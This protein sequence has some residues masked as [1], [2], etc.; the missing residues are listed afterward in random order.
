MANQIEILHET[1]KFPSP[2]F[3]VIHPIAE[4]VFI[5]FCGMRPD[6][7]LLV[8]RAREEAYSWKE[9]FG[10]TISADVLTNRLALYVCQF[11][12]YLYLRPLG[13]SFFIGSSDETSKQL[14]TLNAAGEVYGW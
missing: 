13:A 3:N 4:N 6:G 11:T 14:F 5:S 1:V 2:T 10:T 12:E 9:K 7:L 8:E